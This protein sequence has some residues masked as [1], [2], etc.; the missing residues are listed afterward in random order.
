MLI[1]INRIY[2]NLV[3]IRDYRYKTCLKRKEDLIFQVG[4]QTMTIP[5]KKIRSKVFYKGE[6]VYP[7]KF[8][9]P[10]KLISFE[11]VPDKPLSEEDIYKRYLI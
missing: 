2:K 5:Y 1:T 8:G 3:D 4:K 10:Y 6:K 9:R 7:S 11:F